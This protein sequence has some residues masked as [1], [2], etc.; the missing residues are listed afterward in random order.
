MRNQLLAAVAGVA[1]LSTASAGVVYEIKSV[2]Y[3]SGEPVEE[4]INASVDGDN[5]K[6]VMGGTADG[7]ADEMIFRGSVPEMIMVDHKEK[8]YYVM[9]E[10]TIREIG[11]QMSDIERQMQEA[12]KDVPPEQRP[13]IEQMMKSRMPKGMQGPSKPT[14][15]LNRTPEKGTR[16]GYPCVKYELLREGTLMQEMW[17][18][19]WSNIEG[20]ADVRDAFLGMSEF[21]Q[22]LRDAMPDFVRDDDNMFQNMKDMDGFPVVSLDYSPDGTLEGESKLVSAARQSIDTAA[23]GPPDGYVREEMRMG[24]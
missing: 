16:N 9:D 23:F 21:F 11:N 5:L 6:M 2:R 24:R 3:G 20:G 8:R 19:D 12:L 17:V 1:L 18:T 14:F 15:Q 10:S 22:S 4:F 7:N 13:M